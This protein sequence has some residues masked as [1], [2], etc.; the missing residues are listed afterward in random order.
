MTIKKLKMGYAG[1][2]IR[3]KGDTWARRIT[4]WTPYDAKR[5]VG[6]PPMRWRQEIERRVGTNWRREA[7]N[8]ELWGK[9]GEAYA[10]EWAS[11]M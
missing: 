7:Q 1:H 8:R 10:R 9:I 6:R 3:K 2:M 4:E 5:K 11:G